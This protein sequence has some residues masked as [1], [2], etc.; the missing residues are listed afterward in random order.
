[1][2]IFYAYENIFNNCLGFCLVDSGQNL[3]PLPPAKIRNVNIMIP[4]I[5]ECCENAT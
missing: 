3:S 4:P 2:G 5:L 1:V